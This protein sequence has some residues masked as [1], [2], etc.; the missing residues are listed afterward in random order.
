M[1]RHATAAVVAVLAAVSLAGCRSGSPAANVPLPPTTT[2]T[3]LP[4]G[5]VTG[6][7]VA[8]DQKGTDAIKVVSVTIEG[9]PG[10]LAIHADDAG[11][12]G[13]VVGKAHIP[14]GTTRDVVVHLDLPSPDGLYWPILHVDAGT[15]G[16]WEFPG[17]DTPVKVGTSLVMKR[18]KLT[19]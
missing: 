14:E 19:A 16:T 7:L 18:V 10:W 13:V 3:Q 6:A 9:A 1:G 17:P 5:T 11:R 2:T 4:A 12:P 15:V 8:S